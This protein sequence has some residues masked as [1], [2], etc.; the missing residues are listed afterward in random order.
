MYLGL[1]YTHTHEHVCAYTLTHA[2]L[3]RLGWEAV[4]MAQ[5]VGVFVVQ[6]SNTHVQTGC[7]HTPPNPRALE[8]SKRHCLESRVRQRIRER[9]LVFSSAFCVSTCAYMHTHRPHPQRNEQP[10]LNYTSYTFLFE[11]NNLWSNQWFSA[12]PLPQAWHSTHTFNKTDSQQNHQAPFMCRSPQNSRLFRTSSSKWDFWCPTT[13]TPDHMPTA[14]VT[15]SG[16]VPALHLNS[17]QQKEEWHH[18]L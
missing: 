18:V 14:V 15:S 5:W 10:G 13:H 16:N 4:E 11:K 12:I 8:F 1:T 6:I 2:T 3:M 17:N 9:H 7:D